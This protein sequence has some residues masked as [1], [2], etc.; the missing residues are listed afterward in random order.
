M[1]RPYLQA[2]L[3]PLALPTMHTIIKMLRGCRGSCVE[4]RETGKNGGN[5]HTPYSQSWCSPISTILQSTYTTKHSC[6][7]P[8]LVWKAV[9]DMALYHSE[10]YIYNIQYIYKHQYIYNQDNRE[11]P[12][13]LIYTKERRYIFQTISGNSYTRLFGQFF[14]FSCFLAYNL[15]N[16]V[17]LSCSRHHAYACM[18]HNMVALGAVHILRHKKLTKKP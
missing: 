5:A 12:W 16:S 14:P 2:N 7:T 17:H 6:A 18:V 13:A 10:M 1:N 8:T 11:Q 3:P 9:K 15:R 4:R